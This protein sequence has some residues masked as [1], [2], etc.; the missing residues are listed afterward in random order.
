VRR[1]LG[2]CAICLDIVSTFWK[3]STKPDQVQSSVA[4]HLALS[5]QRQA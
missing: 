1:G 3:M 4:R 2:L 5:P